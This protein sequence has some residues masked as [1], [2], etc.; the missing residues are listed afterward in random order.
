METYHNFEDIRPY[1]DDEVAGMIQILLKDPIFQNVL[2]A[3]FPKT[4]QALIELSFKE[5]KTKDDFQKRITYNIFRKLAEQTTGTLEC[6]G[7]DHLSQKRNYTFISNHRDIVLDAAWLN[8]LLYEHGHSTSEIA[9]GDNLFVQKWIEITTRLNKSFVVK[10]GLA[11]RQMLEA[12]I[13]LSNYIHYAITQK[14]ASV[15]IAQREGRAKDSDD[16]TQESLIKMLA[17]GGNGE[18]VI[19]HLKEL[20]IIPLTISYEYDPCDYLKAKEFQLKRDNEHY[21]KTKEED[22]RNMK[23]GLKNYKGRVHFRASYN[24]LPFLEELE[25]KELARNEI[26]TEVAQYI[27][28]Q[29][30][31]N[32]HIYPCNYIAYDMLYGGKQFVSFYS[33]DEEIEFQKYLNGQIDK[34]DIPHKD[35]PFLRNKIL[36][37]YSNPLKNKMAADET[38]KR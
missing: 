37:M 11:G 31:H 24:I 2:S 8:I 30:H 25:Q 36:E 27:D 33:I 26:F 20:N 21:K 17:I 16:R 38:L 23:T 5:I 3:V 12:S 15:W 13:T 34:I 28:R 4:P 18:S 35:V 29:I 1:N 7:L 32:Y 14:N 19:D 10:R 9:I 6:S 22:F